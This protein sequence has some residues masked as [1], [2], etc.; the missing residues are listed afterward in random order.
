M[1]EER[2]RE[3]DTDREKER[4]GEGRE[5]VGTIC[6]GWMTAWHVASPH[7]SHHDIIILYSRPTHSTSHPPGHPNPRSAALRSA[8][9]LIRSITRCYHCREAA[10]AVNDI[11]LPPTVTRRRIVSASS[12]NCETSAVKAAR[13]GLII[14][15]INHYSA[16][17]NSRSVIYQKLSSREGL[18]GRNVSFRGDQVGYDE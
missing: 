18:G 15:I 14:D 1:R 17:L 2:E 10:P 5:R 4:E 11:L 8:D 12:A 16:E 9:S 3:A 7:T 6:C 13:A